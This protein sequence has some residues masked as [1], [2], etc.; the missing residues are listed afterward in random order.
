MQPRLIFPGLVIFDCD[1][2]LVDSEPF[3]ERALLNVLE[4][5]ALR[6]D[7]DVYRSTFQGLTNEAVAELLADQWGL[8]LPDEFGELITCEERRLMAGQL[9]AIPGAKNAVNSIANAGAEICVASNG[10]P[11]AIADR[12][13]ITGLRRFFSGRIFSADQVPKGKPHPR[14]FKLAADSMGFSASECV[15]IEDS[16]PGIEAGLAAGM[17][18][19]AYVA[20]GKEPLP[21]LCG[22]EHFR[23]M[24]LLPSLLG[25]D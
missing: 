5:I 8:E 1:G 21:D 18:V 7:T 10:P 3:N 17:N 15:V 9:K 16:K 2:V 19:L 6:I 24:Q 13:N 14:L 25:L 23:E 4:R 20:A 12:L 22:V 11:K